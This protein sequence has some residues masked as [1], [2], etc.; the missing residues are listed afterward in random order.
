MTSEHHLTPL[1]YTQH[2]TS[3]GALQ[4]KRSMQI[5]VEYPFIKTSQPRSQTLRK[6]RCPI[7]SPPRKRLPKKQFYLAKKRRVLVLA[8]ATYLNFAVERPTERRW[9]NTPNTTTRGY[10]ISNFAASSFPFLSFRSDAHAMPASTRISIRPCMHH[11]FLLIS[12]LR[13]S[14]GISVCCF[15]VVPNT[16]H[17]SITRTPCTAKRLRPTHSVT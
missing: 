11:P 7:P 3:E 14:S 1:H 13:P 6:L 4:R 10:E 9:K 8:C 16:I 2:T 15:V 17:T 5:R 12:S